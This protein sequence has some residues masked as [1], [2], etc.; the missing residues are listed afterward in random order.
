ML[1]SVPGVYT[2]GQPQKSLIN[3]PDAHEHQIDFKPK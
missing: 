3:G 2:V 1:I